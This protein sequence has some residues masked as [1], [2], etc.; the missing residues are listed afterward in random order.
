MAENSE[1]LETSEIGKIAEGIGNELFG[2]GDSTPSNPEPL[3]GDSP[4]PLQGESSPASA[5]AALPPSYTPKALPK[6][7]KKEMDAHWGKLPP[8]VHD[9]VYDREADVMR[10]IQMYKQG[11]DQWG[12]L[13]QPFQPVLREYPDVNPVQLLQNLMNNHLAMVKGTPEQRK[14]LAQQLIKSYGVELGTPGQGQ[15]PDATQAE[16]AQLRNELRQLQQGWTQAQQAQYKSEVDAAKVKIDAFAKDPKHKY[17]DEVGADI[18][19]LISTGVA[20]DLD[21]AY[22]QAC[23]LNPGVRAKLLAEQPSL[24]KPPEG[25]RPKP[26]N[27]NGSG[28]GTPK[29]RKPATIEDTINS[30]VNKHYGTH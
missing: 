21:S 6:S 29:P 22:E 12:Q 23:W 26:T 19:R 20:A 15:A 30:V 1:S 8:E 7:W 14:A 3:E 24:V 28:E 2:G 13:L 4:P 9:Y 27:I 5:P 10:G 18:L 25:G 17:W 11:H 16:L